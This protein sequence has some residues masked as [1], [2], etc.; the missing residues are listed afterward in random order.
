MSRQNDIPNNESKKED[1]V[2]KLSAF[3][4][5][6]SAP[7]YKIV[8]CHEENDGT[9]VMEA[10]DRLMT[11]D[12]ENRVT[13]RSRTQYAIKEE[14]VFIPSYR[15]GY[16]SASS[17]T[18]E[19]LS[20]D[21]LWLKMTLSNELF[22]GR[23]MMIVHQKLPPW[24]SLV[25]ARDHDKVY[26]N[27]HEVSTQFMEFELSKYHQIFQTESRLLEVAKHTKER[28]LRL[29]QERRRRIKNIKKIRR[30]QPVLM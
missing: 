2:E 8:S 11:I 7:K 19:F 17:I 5:K 20:N 16:H 23:P 27:S 13:Y 1:P 22:E 12:G 26:C 24:P 18:I 4:K 28:L 25:L 30:R 29:E 21:H 10:V 6:F 9:L 3:L 15:H 14:G